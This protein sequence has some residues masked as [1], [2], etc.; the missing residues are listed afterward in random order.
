MSKFCQILGTRA[1]KGNSIS[2]SHHKTRRRFKP[3][4]QRKRYAVPSLGRSIV[5]TVTPR[6]MKTIDRKGI[7]AVVAQLIARGDIRIDAQISD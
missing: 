6:G 5:L 4:L 3:N 1:G 2:H 7:E